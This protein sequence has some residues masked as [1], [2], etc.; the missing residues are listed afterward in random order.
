MVGRRT[1]TLRPLRE[2]DL[3]EL[4]C[5]LPKTAAGLG[6]RRWASEEALEDAAAEDGVLIAAEGEPVGF[7][8]YEVGA[9]ER[10]AARVRLLAVAPGRRRLGVGSRAALALERRLAGSSARIY[11]PV[12]AKL[13]LAFYFWL[14]LGYRPLTQR[15]WP[16]PPEEPPAAWMV[17]SLR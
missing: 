4:A 9:P 14:R 2:D 3:P 1:L 16:A 13:G 12:P 6:C 15:E 8:A 17:R 11:V 7:L 5:W 10:D